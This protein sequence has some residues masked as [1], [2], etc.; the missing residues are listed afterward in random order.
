MAEGDRQVYCTKCGSIISSG[1]RF[2]GVCGARVS[3]D[4][5]GVAPTQEIPTLTQPPYHVAAPSPGRS[6]IV[7]LIAGIGALIVVVLVIGA[8][9]AVNLLGNDTRA[10]SKA[11][12]PGTTTVKAKAPAPKGKS[13]EETTRA[14]PASND[15][16]DLGVGDSVETRG[17]RATL[18]EVRSLPK[19]DFDQP[20]G[21]SDD[22]FVATDLT[23]ENTSNEPVSISSLLE[24]SLKDE[25][26]YSASQSVH[27]D[28]KQLTEGN[29][30]PGQ[31]TS[32]ELVYEVPPD[33]QGLQ[34]DYSPFAGLET[35]TWKIGD[36][37][38]LS[39]PAG[40]AS[41]V[42]PDSVT[43]S[44]TSTPAPDASGNTIS[45]DA[46]KAVDGQI[47]TAWNVDGSGV[48]ESITLNYDEPITVSSIGIVPGYDKVDSSDGTYRFYQLY[49][50]KTAKIE[51][52]DGS[53][54]EASF[55]RDPQMQF[56]DVPETETDSIKI[57]IKDSYSPSTTSPEGDTYP[58]TLDKAAISE[59]QV[60]GP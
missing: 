43:A 23:F 14:K 44:A 32:G 22:E 8:I 56:T 59:I 39:G 53:T 35:Y 60:E 46:E 28:Q 17:I 36:A 4:A 24:F 15:S 41:D 38:S 18:N 16:E 10:Q 37:G 19:S 6:R 13:S 11:P 3:A 7:A 55:D 57:T 2:C 45:Y 20:L 1:D 34:V 33:A 40:S 30:A 27:S 31:K 49:V 47:D 21:D 29:L 58:Y 25:N 50:I 52:S 54:V 26:G 5:P 42:Q 51:F 12:V 48:G 9:F